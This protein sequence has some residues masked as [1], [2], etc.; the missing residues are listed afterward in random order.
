VVALTQQYTNY[1]ASS[2]VGD[3]VVVLL[4]GLV[5]LARPR[6]FAGAVTGARA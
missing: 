2:G 4:L 5:L 6:G 3:M 1:Y